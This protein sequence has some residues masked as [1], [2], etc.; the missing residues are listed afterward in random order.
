MPAHEAMHGKV[1]IQGGI[2]ASM[3]LPGIRADQFRSYVESLLDEAAPGEGFVLGMGDNVPP[4]ADFELVRSVPE[5]L[6]AWNR[7]HAGQ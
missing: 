6:E 7:E 2:A 4:N 1:A 3:V 5:I